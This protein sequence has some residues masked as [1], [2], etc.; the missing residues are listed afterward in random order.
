[1][2]TNFLLTVVV[3]YLGRVRPALLVVV[4]A[5][6]SAYCDDDDRSLKVCSL[7]VVQLSAA[8]CRRLRAC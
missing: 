5:R 7:D 2:T 1:M 4:C 6:H 8:R 3:A